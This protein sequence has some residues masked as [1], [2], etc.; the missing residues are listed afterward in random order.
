MPF[1]FFF[2]ES[3]QK[4]LVMHDSWHYGAS[5]LVWQSHGPALRRQP[6][7][8]TICCFLQFSLFLPGFSSFLPLS[9]KMT[10]KY[11]NKHKTKKIHNIMLNKHREID[12][13]I[14]IIIPLSNYPA[15]VPCSSPSK[16]QRQT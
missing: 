5:L 14:M 16:M 15:L 3:K 2:F 12:E 1:F 11:K 8:F 4:F 9:S 6:T 13:Q 10:T 7:A